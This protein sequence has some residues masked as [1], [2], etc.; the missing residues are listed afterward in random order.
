MAQHF[1]TADGRRRWPDDVSGQ[2]GSY[3]IESIIYKPMSFVCVNLRESAVKNHH[4]HL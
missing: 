1:S 2:K 4:H 3:F